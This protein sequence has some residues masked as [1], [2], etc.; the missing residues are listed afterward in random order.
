MVST[1][2]TKSSSLSSFIPLLCRLCYF[3]RWLSH[4]NF[5]LHK[6][7]PTFL[8]FVILAQHINFLYEISLFIFAHLLLNSSPLRISFLFYFECDKF[9]SLH[10]LVTFITHFQPP[11]LNPLNFQIPN[12]KDAIPLLSLY[13]NKVYTLLSATH[14]HFTV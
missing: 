4:F 7:L 2:S 12:L 1:H 6:N 11:S 3:L 5:T 10:P 13:W 9:N 14:F 8:N